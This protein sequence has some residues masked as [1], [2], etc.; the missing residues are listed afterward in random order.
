MATLTSQLLVRLVD[1]VTGPARAAAAAL[2]GLNA[3]A[4]GAGSGTALVA[5][6]SRVSKAMERNSAAIA[7]MQGKLYGAA[8]AGYALHKTLTPTIRTAMEFESVL[9]DLGQKADIS[10]KPLQD[11]GKRI[12]DIGRQTRQGAL[13]AG[14]AVDFLVG[15]GLGGKTDA[16]NVEAALQMAPG[17]GKA[18]TAYRGD[19]LE[20]S[21]AA[22]AAFIN[23]KVP[24]E[25]MGL[26]FDIMAKS[27]KLGGFELKDMAREF[28]AITAAAEETGMRGTA[29]IADLAAALQ[30]ARKGARDGEQAANN[31]AN[32]FQKLTMKETLSNFKKFGVDILGELQYAAKKG[33]SPIEHIMDVLKKVTKNN[34]YLIS[35]IFGDKQV[36][37]FIRPMWAQMEEYRRIRAETLKAQGTV[38]ADF[39]RRTETAWGKLQRF[40]SSMESLAI[41]LGNTLLPGFTMLIDKLGGLAGMFEGLAERFPMV[42]SG[43]AGLA[44]GMI[45]LRVAAL[46]TGIS[47]RVAYNGLLLVAAG[48]IRALRVLRALTLVPLAAMA[49]GIAGF[50][51]TLGVRAAVAT[52]A[53]GRAPGVFAR[54]GDAFLVLGRGIARMP[55]A[56]LRGVGA[57]LV[58]LGPAGWA[59][60]AGV[61]AV[62]W[63]AAFLA[64]NW[65]KLKS[66]GGGFLEG[67]AGKLKPASEALKPLA[68]AFGRIGSVLSSLVPNLSGSNAEWKS[69]GET[70]GGTVAGA[71]NKVADAINS[72]IGFFGTAISKARELGNAIASWRGGGA[73]GAIAGA[74]AAGAAPP[75]RAR[76]GQVSRGQSYI[77]GERRPE[78]FTPGVS[79]R[80]TPRVP[81]GNKVG[82]AVTVTQ[83][84][85]ITGGGDARELVDQVKREFRRELTD[86]FHGIQ[87]DV[88]LGF[89]Y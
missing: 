1:G 64:K 57:L 29:A 46:V 76:G 40:T 63:G 65:D 81:D 3:A 28:P 82:G 75:G 24:A 77:V 68:D 52:A 86:L 38:E 20:L 39:A 10:G 8:T 32:F 19:V 45:A 14:R 89:G 69:W 78:L 33:I 74:A 87:G 43:L 71:V 35:Q 66:F 67:F 22:H 84:F 62:T 11:I 49:R 83:N 30:V 41:T 27:G 56:A 17:L 73:A 31:L 54:L 60:A 61:A 15:M 16:D 50:F 58:G 18:A 34:R 2:R 23:L 79:G 59:A 12:R 88:R 37:E 6:Q 70:V 44:A 26:A 48:G 9:E 25:Q 53:A 51:G 85:H 13:G 21:R 55:M 42:A 4:L 72:V 47:G 36:K 5:M 7:A 80:I